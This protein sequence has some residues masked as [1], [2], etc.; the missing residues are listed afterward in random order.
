MST[1]NRP[2]EGVIIDD[3]AEARAAR[4][5]ALEQD[6]PGS[7]NVPSTG[8][9]VPQSESADQTKEQSKLIPRHTTNAFLNFHLES[10]ESKQSLKDDGLNN[11]AENNVQ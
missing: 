10:E 8:L 7:R 4:A 9:N 1:A 3:I 5:R 2:H 11:A 6:F